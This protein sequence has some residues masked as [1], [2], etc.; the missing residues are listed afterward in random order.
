MVPPRKKE[1]SLA[2][3]DATT[4]KK[5]ETAKA[6]SNTD[7]PNSAKS[8][9]PSKASIASGSGASSK[10]ASSLASGSSPNIELGQLLSETPPMQPNTPVRQS[11]EI[12][13]ETLDEVSLDEDEDEDDDDE[14]EAEDEEDEDADARFSTVALRTPSLPPAARENKN[15]SWRNSGIDFQWQRTSVPV[16][17]ESSS[18]RQSQAGSTHSRSRPTTLP[19][20]PSPQAESAA[21]GNLPFLLA[22]LDT[23]KEASDS[24]Y[25]SPRGSV[26]ASGK[27]KEKFDVAHTEHKEG[28][29]IDWDFWG[30]VIADY[31]QVARSEPEALAAAISR[32]IPSALRGMVWQLMSASK[33]TEMEATYATL[34]KET[35]PHEKSIHRDLGRT[36]PHHAFFS[37]GQ[38]IGQE[39]L[40]NVLKAYAL[41]D[42]EVGYC[43]G[44]AFIVATL[45]LNM[46]DEEAFCI[47]IRLMYSYGLRSMFLPE[48]PGLQLRLFQF[49][50]LVEELLPV[51]H[52]H[53]V[54]QGVKSSMYCSQWFLTMFS[55]RFPLDI[56]FRIFDNVF[57]SGVEAI[58]GFSIVLLQKNEDELLG[59]SF[60][61]ILEYLKNSVFDAYQTSDPGE[62]SSTNPGRATYRADEFVQEASQLKITPFMLDSYS[63]E[64]ED[65]VRQRKAHETEMDTLRNINRSLSNQIKTLE[66][67]L[68]Q[69]NADHVDLVKQLV[70]TKIEKE[71]MESELVKYK[72]LYAELM[73]QS[74]D[75]L[76]SHRI[77][78][79]TSASRLSSLSRSTN[80]GH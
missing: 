15:S 38:G 36:F 54:R 18:Q 74:E 4:K 6:S 78:S 3:A 73:H 59:R 21:P 39:N 63:S 68:A 45:L 22:R 70:M 17:A 7:L 60:D 20:A 72:M 80:S 50:R 71:E 52:I 32:G 79:R 25:K 8:L 19:P 41:Y 2:A 29:V 56:V 24:D 65:T 66:A 48:M 10:K 42:P 55:Y 40:F 76:S 9:A 16:V 46:P 69:M 67:S 31:E 75:S 43:Q 1:L 11:E 61:Q 33:D 37:D 34:L 62:G 5:D 77:S 30:V 51:L 47:L 26:D 13:H 14:D 27:L 23:A 35:S 53:F 57:A 44:L 28:D 49:D 58:F 12:D 64:W